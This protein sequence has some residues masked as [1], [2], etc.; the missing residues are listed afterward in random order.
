MTQKAITERN[1]MINAHIMQCAE[2]ILPALPEG[3]HGQVVVNI[4]DGKVTTFK[5]VE[6]VKKK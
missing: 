6:T 1:N 2:N 3:Y 5:K 4:E